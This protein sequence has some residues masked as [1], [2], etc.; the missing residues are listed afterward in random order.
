MMSIHQATRTLV[1]GSLLGGAG[2]SG[3]LDLGKGE[4][5]DARLTAD[6]FTW[7]CRSGEDEVEQ[8]VYGFTIALE[9]APDGLSSRDLPP[10]GSCQGELSMFPL[11]AGVSGTAIPDAGNEIAW[12]TST[13]SGSLAELSPGFYYEDVLGNQFTC[14]SPSDMVSSGITVPTAGS[15]GSISTPSAGELVSVTLGDGSDQGL[16]F[17]EEV[18]VE[19]DASD[20]EES[21]LQVRM[22]REGTAWGSVTCNTTGDDGFDIDDRVWD[23]LNADLNVDTINLYVGFQNS[24]ENS[25]DDELKL[26]ASSRVIYVDVIQDR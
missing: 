23:E 20:W 10:A 11:D 9:Y 24:T 16:V 13:R 19:W 15:L 14:V 7:P 8:G 4:E 3:E 26:R 1:I 22:E 2:C 6:V 12:A 17:G 25:N 5:A 21:W 18:A